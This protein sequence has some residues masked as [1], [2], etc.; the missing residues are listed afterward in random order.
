MLLIYFSFYYTNA[1]ATTK[2]LEIARIESNEN[3]QEN[4]NTGEIR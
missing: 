1:T 2:K 4:T 3:E